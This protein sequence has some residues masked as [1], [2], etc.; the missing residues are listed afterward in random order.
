MFG[1]VVIN[2]SELPAEAAARYEA[3]YCGL[4]RT[5]Q[6]RHGNAARSTLSYDMTFLLIL[7]SSLYEPEETAASG[8]CILHPIQAKPYIQN[9]I[10]DYVAD[11]NVVLAYYKG[12]DNWKD[13]RRLSGLAQSNLLSKAYREVEARYPEKCAAIAACLEEIGA[14]EQAN[15]LNVDALANQ[16]A[17]MLGEIYAYKPEDMWADVLRR[18]GG[19]L[20]RFIYMMDAYEDLPDD[21]RKKRY[22]PLAGYVKSEDYEALCQEGLSMLIAEC[23]DA[24]EVLPLVQDM[25]I[26]R[27][28]LYSGVWTR[29]V[30]IQNEKKKKEEKV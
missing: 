28:V 3:F 2:K 7:L 9:K 26:L 4:C 30:S 22:N 10:S 14:V 19:A 27:N 24:F 6:T 18:M 17:Y 15:T 16:T 29:Y 12:L 11:M 20:G 8:K 23:A 21:R 25:D 1:Y 13:E 5:L